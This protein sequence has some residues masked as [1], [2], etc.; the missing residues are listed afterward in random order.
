MVQST[1]NVMELL[2]GTRAGTLQ[3]HFHVMH[4]M[5]RSRSSERTEV[6]DEITFPILMMSHRS[7]AAK[8]IASR[9]LLV[10]SL[11]LAKL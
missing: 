8:S 6:V 5:D 3:Y 1:V 7:Y 10:V 11:K 9:P 4:R 2:V